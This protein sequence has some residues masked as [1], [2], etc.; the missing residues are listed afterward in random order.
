VVTCSRERVT[1]GGDELISNPHVKGISFTGSTA[2]GRQI[3]SGAGSL[4]KKACVELGGK[5]IC[6]CFYQIAL[7]DA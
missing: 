6:R 2:V 4:L 5:G 3:A 1:E 7:A